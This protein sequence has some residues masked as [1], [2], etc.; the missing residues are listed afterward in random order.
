MVLASMGVAAPLLVVTTGSAQGASPSGRLEVNVMNEV[1]RGGEPEIA[2]DAK[3]P[4]I[5]VLGHTVVGNNYTHDTVQ[6]G[7]KAVEA[8]LQV[9][10]DGGKTWSADNKPIPTKGF[11]DPPNAFLLAH[12]QAAASG[13]TAPNNGGGDPIEASGP[14]G[15]IYAGGVLA[16]AAPPGPPP[17]NFTV[18]QGGIAVFRSTNGGKS[19]GPLHA[20][21]TDQELAS[22]VARG[23]TPAY[24]GFGVVPFDRPWMVVD[25]SNGALYVS[26]TGHPERYVVRSLD[27]GNTWSRVQALDCDEVTPPDATHDVTCSAYPQSGD[28][29]VAASHG[30]LAASYTAKAAPGH[31]CPCVIFETSTDAGAHWNR[32]VVFDNL[33]GGPGLFTAADPAH[34]GRFAMLLLPPAT[35]PGGLPGLSPAKNTPQEVEVVTTNNSGASWSKPTVL[36]DQ[37]TPHITNRPWIA[38]GPTGVLAALWRN[39]NPPYTA[40]SFLVSGY[41]NVFAAVS[42]NNGRTFSAPVQLN[43]QP[44]PPPDPMQLAEDDVS[45]VLVT[46]QYVYG[47]WGDW[48][49]TSKNP[50]A[51]E[52]SPPAAEMNAWIGRVPISA[53]TGHS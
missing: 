41:Q 14:D 19:F 21:L 34:K 18:A 36:G 6:D 16:N 22:M 29:T 24:G 45:W 25:Q 38:Y 1:L 8:G 4:Q 9:S 23:M 46:S 43:S 40:G 42:R 35:V 32:H 2:V 11:T 48:R 33:T 47:S 12:G 7:L 50:I 37:S 17:F 13:Y 5:L 26:T 49:P 44:S 10:T 28:G 27:H 30:I 52:A 3:N 39:A 31:T 53:F 15:S 51:P 20:V